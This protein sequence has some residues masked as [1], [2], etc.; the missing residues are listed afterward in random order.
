MEEHIYDNNNVIINCDPSKNKF[1]IVGFI[2]S[3]ISL[4]FSPFFVFQIVG[5][6]F[7]IL[8]LKSE[9][10]RFATAGIVLC[11]IAVLL[12]IFVCF[13][14]RVTRLAAEDGCQSL[15][16]SNAVYIQEA[17]QS[18][19]IMSD[20]KDLKFG[21]DIEP[22]VERI[23]HYLKEEIQ[24]IASDNYLGLENL[25]LKTL[26][27]RYK[28]FKITYDKKLLDVIVEPSEDGNLVVIKDQ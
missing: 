10:K 8:G 28:G 2:F 25:S 21:E 22:T 3:I 15:D 18:Y 12:G 13:S 26:S 17:L 9:R 24:K 23:T 27:K 4:I 20:D 11:I 6:I 1:A 5:M 7:S 19:V 16:K 14:V